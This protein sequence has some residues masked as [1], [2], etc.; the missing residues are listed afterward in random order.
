MFIKHPWYDSWC[1]TNYW[2]LS[3]NMFRNEWVKNSLLKI[4]INRKPEGITW[5]K[6]GI[7]KWIFASL[8]M[9]MCMCFWHEMY[10][11]LWIMVKNSLLDIV[12]GIGDKK[13]Q[14]A[15]LYSRSA[16]S[17]RGCRCV[18]SVCQGWL[19]SCEQPDLEG[20]GLGSRE[21]G[22]VQDD[23]ESWETSGW[24]CHWSE[25]GLEVVK[26]RGDELN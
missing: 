18:T 26:G 4:E 6:I 8:Y 15:W 22:A 14:S 23:H 17:C 19:R 20:C 25:K 5:G 2:S 7:V 12:L 13:N 1:F 3:I 21:V 24:W 11:L 10:F 16:R 9:C